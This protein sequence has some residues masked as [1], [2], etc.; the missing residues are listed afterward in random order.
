LYAVSAGLSAGTIQQS[1]ESQESLIPGTGWLVRLLAWSL[2]VG[3][4]S[5]VIGVLAPFSMPAP[6]TA[7]NA[8]IDS[9]TAI[10]AIA[11]ACYTWIRFTSSRQARWFWATAGFSLFAM[12]VIGHVALM[13]IGSRNPAAAV[14]GEWCIPVSRI[15]ISACLIVAALTDRIFDDTW[16]KRTYLDLAIGWATFG[17]ASLLGLM[18]LAKH[19]EPLMASADSGILYIARLAPYSI[20]VVA[21]LLT[22]AIYAKK[23]V[24]WNDTLSKLVCVWL[25]P[26]ALSCGVRAVY[27]NPTP[28]VWWQ[29]H[30]LDVTAAA[31]AAIGLNVDSARSDR[32]SAERL[33]ALEAMHDVSW[34]LVGAGNLM[35]MLSAFVEVLAKT[36]GAKIVGLYLAEEDGTMMRLEAAYGASEFLE[37]GKSYSLEPDRR[38]GFHNGHTARA[39]KEQ[40]TQIVSDVFSDVE[41]VPWRWIAQNHGWVVSAPL[42]NRNHALG[43]INLY[44][45]QG[46]AMLPERMHLLET[47]AAL[48]APA[49]ESRKKSMQQSTTIRKVNTDADIL[50]YQTNLP[51]AA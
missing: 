28:N 34:S 2:L 16:G 31:I 51:K 49:I 38:P 24:T 50:I 23:S 30:I 45:H 22:T 29:A 20:A 47:M 9:F 13:I 6:T 46:K 26:T 37:V 36:T 35:A 1:K 17:A 25:L 12:F 21:C 44:V 41:F 40:T 11:V 27:L 8:L 48:V 5:A 43:V 33:G 3:A 32:Q 10:I 19:I 7:A 4:A 42:L 15:V 39:F 14:A 18:L